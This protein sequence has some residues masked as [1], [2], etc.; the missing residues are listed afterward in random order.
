MGHAAD[1]YIIKIK[2]IKI[3]EDRER[4]EERF[5]DGDE[6]IEPA[7]APKMRCFR[8]PSKRNHTSTNQRTNCVGAKRINDDHPQFRPSGIPFSF[9]VSVSFLTMVF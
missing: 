1:K 9:S 2:K 8:S 7:A 5:C 4:V 3:K 6:R